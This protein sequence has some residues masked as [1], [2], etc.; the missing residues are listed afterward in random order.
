[1]SLRLT[2]KVFLTNG[3]FNTSSLSISLALR[4]HFETYIAFL[5]KKCDHWNSACS[6]K[7]GQLVQFRSQAEF[8]LLA[9]FL[10]YS[11]LGGNGITDWMTGTFTNPFTLT[12]TASN[13]EKRL[14][15][16]FFDIFVKWYGT[17]EVQWN[18]EVYSSFGTIYINLVITVI[19]VRLAWVGVR[20]LEEGLR[21]LIY[22]AGVV[23]KLGLV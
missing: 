14:G 18:T 8:D 22:V 13:V 1:M 20:I 4:E 6:E 23:Q 12:S 15:K 5:E 21:Y 10:T 16:C 11:S 9:F 17:V 7:G 19:K 3:I 2:A